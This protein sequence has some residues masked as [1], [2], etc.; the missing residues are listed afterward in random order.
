MTKEALTI[1]IIGG[2]HNGLTAAAY[3]A[4][5]GFSVEVFEKR[6]AIGGLCVNEAP[7]TQSGTNVKVSSVASY[8]GMMRKEIMADLDLASY[9]LKPYLTD[10]VEIVLLDATDGQDQFSFTPRDGGE[11]KAEIASLTKGDQAGWQAFWADIQKAA[12]LIYPRYLSPDL[13][14]QEVVELLQKNGLDKIAD[15]IFAGSL[16][17]LLK[18]YVHSE[19]LMAVAATCTPGF[20]NLVGSVFGCI[21]HGTAETKG[22]FGAWG[23]VLGGM[24]AI[25]EA[26]S[27]AAQANGA[28]IHLGKAIKSLV[29]S[30]IDGAEKV[31]AIELVDGT[32]RQFDLV[33]V[34]AD[35]YVLFEQLL[36]PTAATEEIRRYLKDNRPKVSAAKLHFLLK[37]LPSFRTLTK[38][39]HNHK[40]VIVMA[41]PLEA[42]KAASNEVPN[43]TMPDR[44]MLTMAFPTLEDASMKNSDNNRPNEQVLSVD[45][46]YVPAQIAGCAWSEK[47]DQ[48]LLESAINAIEVQCPE[49]RSLIIDSYVVSPRALAN[50]FNLASLSCWHLP[51]TPEYLFEKRTLPGCAPYETP[52]KNLFLCGAGTYPGGNVTAANGHNLAK[53]L[54]NRFSE[55][56][57]KDDAQRAR[58]HS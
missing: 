28:T 44:L 11:A 2:G 29:V 55:K 6:E 16:V 18:L 21:H 5:Q 12:A 51:M 26:L 36:T 58:V 37:E 35:S 30:N 47:D 4:A 45:V 32:T 7:F 1:A 34:N 27:K 8:F 54:I 49:I 43:G 17:D 24:G 41:P 48:I 56:E 19:G 10:P 38:I 22:E 23:Q 57:V 40:G 3:L 13:T 9:G 14:Q 20:A 46:H 42:V 39:G 53:L 15:H 50:D 31:S 25:T 33:V 52:V